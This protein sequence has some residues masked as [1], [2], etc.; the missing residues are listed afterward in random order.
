MCSMNVSSASDSSVLGDKEIFSQIKK[1]EN[2][3]KC[4]D[5]FKSSEP[6]KTT[7]IRGWKVIKFCKQCDKSHGM[8]T[9][10]RY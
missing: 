8:N 6:R 2:K 3:R 7:Q 5:Y 9:V 10:M 4:L 1:F